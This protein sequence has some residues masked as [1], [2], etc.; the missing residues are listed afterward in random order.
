VGIILRGKGSDEKQF[1]IFLIMVNVV[2]ILLPGYI[3][4]WDE[5]QKL[6][7]YHTTLG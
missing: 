2:T 7:E 3:P 6:P 4:V 5:I 1:A